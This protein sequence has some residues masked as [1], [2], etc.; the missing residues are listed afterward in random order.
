MNA[1]SIEPKPT[2]KPGMPAPLLRTL[3]VC[4]LVD[5][6]ALTE[7]LGDRVAAELVHRLDRLTRD[8]L[9]RHGGR[10]IDKT[11]GFLVMFERPI[12]AVAFA[13]A[14]QRLLREGQAHE[15]APLQARIGIHVGD[16]VLWENSMDDVARGAKPVEVE[17]LVKPVAAR[18][19]SLALP[20]QILLSGIAYTFALRAQGELGLERPPPEWRAHG[21]YQFKGLAEPMT[22]YEVGERGI[23]PLHRPTYS[24]K[25]HREVPWWRRPGVLALEAIVLIAAIAIPTYI[26]MRSPPAI[27]FGNRDWVVIGDLNN[28]TG[29][30][31]FNDSVQSAFRIGLEQSRYVNVL[32]DLKVRKTVAL[33]Q[34][35]PDATRVD[36]AV[37]SEVAIREGARA[38]ILPTLAEIGGRV[39]VTAEVID[40]NTQA[41]VYTESADGSGADSVLPSLDQVDQKLRLRLG[42]ALAVVQTSSE[43]LP[44]VTTAN[45]DALRAY[46]LGLRAY[47]KGQY[48]DA[49]NLYQQAIAFD[50]GFALANMG[51]ARVYEGSSDVAAAQRYIAKAL[52]LRERLPARDQ[53]YLDAW[54]ARS[55]PPEPMLRKWQ[56]LGELYPDYYAAAYNYA[57]FA[58]HL[59]NRAADAMKAIQPALS[60]HNPLRAGAFNTLANFQAAGEKFADAEKNFSKGESLGD[61]R[62]SGIQ[63]ATYAAQRR[64]DDATKVLDQAKP[65]GVPTNDIFFALQRV[66]IDVDRGDW[67]RARKGLGDAAEAALAPGPFFSRI[68]RGRRLSLDGYV[69]P[70]TEQVAALKAFVAD[71]RAAAENRSDANHPDEVFVLL[72]SGYLA[73]QAEDRGLAEAV[74]T[75]AEPLARNSGYPNLEHMLAIVEAEMAIRA[76]KPLDAISR[77]LPSIDGSVLY[78]THVTLA[79]AYAASSK[80]EESLKEA[81]WLA[82]HRGR[83]Y[84]EVNAYQV[85]QGRNVAESDLALLR[86]A[87][88]NAKLGRRELADTA[89]HDFLSAWPNAKQL[90]F[91]APRISA[92][93]QP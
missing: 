52:A 43:P 93:S 91:V 79:D 87:E 10:E 26:S 28:L 86:M 63:A 76:G 56:T 33:M 59:E 6:T 62:V 23:A 82:G 68:H 5:S 57:Y 39:R 47:A 65:I 66:A 64:F 60:E 81:A 8:L 53:L 85:L 78:L 3:A 4:D 90:V 12:Q 74:L 71:A 67:E 22:V 49:L 72:F 69:V 80:N 35:D 14:Y 55:G 21:R 20:G 9:Y 48:A 27:A 31:T 84:L 58:W 18:L 11:D 16:V 51:I 77:L 54:A 29:E 46:A 24:G 83:A 1:I 36:R 45:L 73:T 42:E 40:P 7:K 61:H 32:A 50:P 41:T 38:L 15:A 92:I 19:M 34:R 25:A 44:K 89:L 75:A 13:L 70:R 30:T 37:G 17:G 2:Q 88:L